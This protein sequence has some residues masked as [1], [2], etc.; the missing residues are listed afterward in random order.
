MVGGTSP[1]ALGELS[2]LILHHLPHRGPLLWPPLCPECDNL[3]LHYQ[4]ILTFALRW[5]L[6]RESLPNAGQDREKGPGIPSPHNAAPSITEMESWLGT[7][8]GEVP[9]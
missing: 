8:P 2:V 5:A 7:A 4:G 1:Q 9:H 3:G 6:A